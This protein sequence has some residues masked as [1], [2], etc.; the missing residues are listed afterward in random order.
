MEW[1][2]EFCG[3]LICTYLPEFDLALQVAVLGLQ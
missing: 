1:E 3:L 2:K